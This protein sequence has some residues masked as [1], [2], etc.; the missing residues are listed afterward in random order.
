MMLYE[1]IRQRC[2]MYHD[3]DGYSYDESYASYLKDKDQ[4]K[5]NN[6][7]TLDCDEVKRL[8]RFVNKWK[9]R[10]PKNDET[11]RRLLNNLKNEVPRLNTLHNT[12]LLDVKFDEATMQGIAKCFDTI[13]GS[14]VR[15]D[16]VTVIRRPVGISKMLHVAI[17][18]KLFVMWD[19]AIQAGHG[20]MI[21]T[22]SAYASIFLPKMQRI[23]KCAVKQVEEQENLSRAEAIQ[24]FTEHCK[25]G[26]SL[27]KII[28]EYNYTKYTAKWG[29]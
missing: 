22:G 13:T 11:I 26:N 18:P 9:S 14:P 20:P 3:G 8:V 25:K 17:N 12:T 15:N 4:N 10:V 23:A 21:D 6:P 27:A 16:G 7:A 29:L 5:W 19:G 1:E 28:D 24:S 2:R